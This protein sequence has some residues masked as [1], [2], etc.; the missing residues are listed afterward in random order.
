MEIL[1]NDWLFHA[2]GVLW[3]YFGGC[4]MGKCSLC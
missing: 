3:G 4:K 1:L 2:I